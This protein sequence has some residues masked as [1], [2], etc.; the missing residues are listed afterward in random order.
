MKF[1]FINQ[2]DPYYREERMLRWEALEKPYGIPPGFKSDREEKNCI[3]LIALDK[4]RLVGCAIYNLEKG[5]IFDCVIED[6]KGG[7]ARQMIHK[8]EEAL[9]KKGLSDVHVIAQ[10]ENQSF[11]AN[12]GYVLEGAVFE[13]Y[14]IPYQKMAKKLLISA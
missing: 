14:G 12:L 13:E 2:L 9:Q 1:K 6:G 3:H 11:F 5:E 10:E 8:L 4:K 7:F